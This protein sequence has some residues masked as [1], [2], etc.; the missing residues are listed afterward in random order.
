MK[1][2]CTWFAKAIIAGLLALCIMIG[3]CFFYY[4]LPVHYTNASGA[5]DY[6]W[7]KNFLSMSGTEGFARTHTDENGYVNTFPDKKEEINVLVM[8]SSHS[9]GFNVDS[10]ENFTY[11]LNK[12]LKEKND[13]RYAYNIATSGHTLLRCMKNLDAALEKYEPTDCVVIETATAV[14]NI[15]QMIQLDNGEFADLQ[16]HNSGIVSYLQ[17]IN[18]FRLIYA[19]ISNAMDKED[20]NDDD[21]DVRFESEEERAEFLKEYE[22]YLERILR[23][24]S[25]TAGKHNC[26][27]LI[28]HSPQ[29]AVDYYGN[30]IKG[31]VSEEEK[32]F[33]KLCEKYDIDYINMFD[34]YEEMYEKTNHLPQGFSNTAIGRGHAN[35]YGHN[36]IAE[37]LYDFLKRGDAA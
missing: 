7:D 32:L 28:L 22:L 33:E 3:V 11:L 21:D 4:N 15:E 24:C 13:D 2:I 14:W 6:F 16:S 27:V 35:R 19:Q 30:I 31:E 12:K 20:S 29:M 26:R 18:I 34:S 36:C 10:D 5:T 8:G 1:K 25:E 9:E 17:K 23:K 37:K